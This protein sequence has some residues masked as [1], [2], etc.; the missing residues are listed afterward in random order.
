MKNIIEGT[1]S[2]VKK[3]IEELY[4]NFKLTND[5]INTLTINDCFLIGTIYCNNGIQKDLNGEYINFEKVD[6]KIF[7][8]SLFVK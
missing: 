5:I 1:Y 2:Y 8:D 3:H 7:I 4:P 6:I